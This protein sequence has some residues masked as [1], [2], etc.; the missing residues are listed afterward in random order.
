MQRDDVST[1]TQLGSNETR[2][3]YDEPCAA[4]LETFPN[5][6]PG[7]DY[8]ATYKFPEFTSLCPR[9]GQ[10][11]FAEIVIE[12]VPD[13]LCVESK[14]LKLYFFTFRQ[15]GSFMETITN[16]ILDDF[17]SACLPRW[18]RV[19]GLFNARGGL[20]IDVVAEHGKR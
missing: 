11:D 5:K 19:T 10:P 4:M 3:E 8:V 7:R 6:Y 17:V 20:K 12:Y 2:Y 14:S 1:L 13:K 15:Y 16:K 9:T 18:C